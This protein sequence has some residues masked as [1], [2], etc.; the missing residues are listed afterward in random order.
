MPNGKTE[1]VVFVF[2]NIVLKVQLEGLHAFSLLATTAR[3]IE[4]EVPFTLPEMMYDKVHNIWLQRFLR[5]CE[6]DVRRVLVISAWVRD[7]DLRN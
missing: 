3:S 2:V 6:V 4:Q 1:F 7:V 5:S